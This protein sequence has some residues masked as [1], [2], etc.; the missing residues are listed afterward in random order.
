MVRARGVRVAVFCGSSDG[1]HPRYL[2]A[3][4]R[5]GRLLAERGIQV[6]YGGAQAGLMG[7]VADAALAGG[8]EVVG[9]M[10]RGRIDR[11]LAHGSLTELRAVGDMRER[12]AVISALADGFII[13][14]G[15]FGTIEELFDVLTWKQLGLH[16]KPIV[17]CNPEGY[18]DSILGWIDRA[19]AEGFLT[20]SDRALLAVV[21]TPE[22][23]AD[24]LESVR[25]RQG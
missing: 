18:F 3:G 21:P 16:D 4:R 1:V 2:E 17:V 10:P 8:G 11:A 23:A 24:L 13:L 22:E 25:G 15:G 12:Q 9:V 7:A 20:S 6:I 14:P 19:C 5:L